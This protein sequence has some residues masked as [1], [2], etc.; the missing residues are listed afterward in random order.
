[1][2]A[3][4]IERLTKTFR[5]G[6]KALDAVDLRVEE[7]E[8]VALIG[9]SGSGKSTLLRH[10]AGF[11]ASDAAPSHVTLLGRPIQQNGKIVRE[12][13][14]IRRDVAFVF[15]QFNLVGRLSVITNVLIGALTRVSLWRRLSGRF[16]RDERAL[17]MDSL[18]AMGIG[19]HALERASNL[20]GGQ[21]QRA[22]LARALVQR[23]RIV[24]ADEPIASLDP[25]SARR[26]MELMQSLNRDHKL[27]VIVSLHQ[28]DIAMKYCTRTVALRDGRVVYD[29]ASAKLTPMLLRELYVAAAAELLADHDEREHPPATFASV[30]TS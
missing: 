29:G 18:T 11:I 28:I 10:I 16:P 14:A 22:A 13:R 19:E 25:E 23:A 24:L 3:I 30:A 2:D 4:R 6:R 5:N 7:G 8:M 17:A 1:M 12:V 21:Q 27:T 15:Q 20:S 9:A 26:V